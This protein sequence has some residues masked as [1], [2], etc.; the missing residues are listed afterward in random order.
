MLGVLPFEAEID[1]RKLTFFGQLCRL[2]RD[3]AVKQLFLL[4]MSAF[5]VRTQMTGYFLDI[6][7]ILSRYGLLNYLETY[8]SNGLCPGKHAWKRIITRSILVNSY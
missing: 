3:C 2:S 8:Y 1:K 7:M 5:M 6:H 4:L